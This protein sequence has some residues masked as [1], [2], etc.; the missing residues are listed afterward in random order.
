MQEFFDL[1]DIY[2]KV[3]A[4]DYMFHR[5]I[6]AGV[7]REL[8]A[9]IAGQPFSFLDLGC[10]DAAT[11]VPVV[12]GLALKRY[13]G[14][15]LSEPALALATKNLATLPC[16]VELNHGDISTALTEDT[17]SYDVIYSSYALHRPPTHEKADFFL[18][19]K[20]LTFSA[21]RCGASTELPYCCSWTSYAR[22]MKACKP[23]TRAIATGCAAA[24]TLWTR[25]KWT[26]F[27]IMSSTMICPNHSLY[28]RLKP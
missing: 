5:E 8:H 9:Q 13:K 20:R 16:P 2:Q 27:V 23:F 25:M 12:K 7:R 11:L 19:T 14:V 24:G 21:G 15:D 28:C 18:R 1:W 10:G 22:K 17:A 6:G 26:W 3:V 4:A